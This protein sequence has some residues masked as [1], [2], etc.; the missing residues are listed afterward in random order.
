MQQPYNTD[1]REQPGYASTTNYAPPD[2][3]GAFGPTSAYMQPTNGVPVPYPVP[4]GVPVPVPVPATKEPGYTQALTSLVLGVV[5]LA[6]I[7]MMLSLLLFLCGAPLGVTFSA[8]GII[9]G[10]LGLRSPSRRR[11]A[12]TGIVLS[13]APLALAIIF[14]ILGY[15]GVGY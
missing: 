9:F 14:A 5:S 1:P 11:M 2:S 7:P 4:Y 12:I 15:F 3:Q 10:V 6:S 13:S 8:L